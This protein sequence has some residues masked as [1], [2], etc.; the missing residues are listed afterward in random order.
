MIFEGIFY[1]RFKRFNIFSMVW[2]DYA[3]YIYNWDAEMKRA[4]RRQIYKAC[5]L[6]ET[7]KEHYACC[8]I[9]T[10]VLASGNLFVVAVKDYCSFYGKTIHSQWFLGNHSYVSDYAHVRIMLL[11]MYLE[12]RDDC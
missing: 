11:L 6:L 10:S 1:G 12:A 2:R 9:A 5:E 7:R 4:T 3:A 8:A